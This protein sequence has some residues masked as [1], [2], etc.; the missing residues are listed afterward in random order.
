M[1]AAD[2]KNAVYEKAGPSAAMYLSAILVA[3]LPPAL[4]LV[5]LSQI[6]PFA[7]HIVGAL[8]HVPHHVA[9]TSI[10]LTGTMIAIMWHFNGRGHGSNGKLFWLSWWFLTGL[11]TF[12]AV[13]SVPYHPCFSIAFLTILGPLLLYP[14][15]ACFKDC[16][17]LWFRV[18]WVATGCSAALC[19]LT[20]LPWILIGPKS[21]EKWT[22]W[23]P[24]T[25]Q[26]VEGGVISWK[27]A[28][29]TWACPPSMFL[30]LSVVAV[31]CWVRM[32]YVSS[33]LRVEEQHLMLV[34]SMKQVAG[35]LF[36]LV[37]L[38]WIQATMNATGAQEF[39]TRREDMSD[40]VVGLAF[41]LFL[42]MSLWVL[43]TV[44]PSE[45]ATAVKE[46]KVVQESSKMIENDWTRA[47]ILLLACLPIGCLLLCDAAFNCVCGY[48]KARRPLFK[49]TEGW[50]WT[51][52]LV[53]ASWLGIIYVSVAVGVGKMTTVLL[54]MINEHFSGWPVFTVSAVMFVLALLIFLFPASPGPPI[55]VVMGIVICSSA[56]KQ[57]WTFSEG[58]LWATMVAFFMK[59]AFTAVAQKL[60]GEP[61]SNND[62][63]RQLVGIQTPYM[64]A[65]EMLLKVPGVTMAKVSLLV[66]GPDWPVAV[67]CGVLRLSVVS[68]QLCIAPV[69]VQSV[70]PSVLAGALL[71]E[72][73]HASGD[74]TKRTHGMAEVT[75]VVAGGL[76]LIMGTMAFYYVQDVLETH[77]EKLS[78]SRPEDAKL[79]EMERKAEALDRAFWHESAWEVLPLWLKAALI[80]GVLSIE[81]CVGILCMQEACF[82]KFGLMSSV[83]KDLDGH[84]LS[85]IK[86]LGWLAL[87]L[88]ALDALLLG[89]FYAYTKQGSGSAQAALLEKE[90]EAEGKQII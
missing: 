71:L 53:K 42:T 14:L 16:E 55:Y 83:E 20:W 73:S 78:A 79:E 89:S 22:D 58:L 26:L 84:V 19:L 13:L 23:N 1:S 7:A 40:E 30:E 3:C 48:S 29:A 59:L 33:S 8:A 31:L 52:I 34:S 88:A 11:A 37:M 76:Q 47:F 74:E 49:W 50:R 68:V 32:R 72:Q 44:G 18:A 43:D 28:F 9:Y 17:A 67:L 38:I 90:R 81:A 36:A 64:R 85:I 63:V 62:S 45:V 66:G 24:P 35:W 10:F 86:P 25:R 21:R 5:F 51:S 61:F 75:L 60:I 70:F 77:Y 15:R 80:L 56:A 12:S 4:V 54:A 41:L 27:C 39:N 69:L 46:S 65:I 6:S 57:G 82:R 87:L 2:E